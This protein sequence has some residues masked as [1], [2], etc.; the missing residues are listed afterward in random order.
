MTSLKSK[1][2]EPIQRRRI[3]KFNVGLFIAA[4]VIFI[5]IPIAVLYTPLNS[6]IK[7]SNI[8]LFICFLETIFLFFFLSLYQSP[9]GKMVNEHKRGITVVIKLVTVFIS[10]FLLL[11]FLLPVHKGVALFGSITPIIVLWTYVYFREICK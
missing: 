11:Y 1:S 6:G 8:P 2:T 7:Q 5:L 10:T 4:V 3:H 9:K